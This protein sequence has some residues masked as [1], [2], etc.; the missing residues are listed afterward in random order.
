MHERY[1][2]RLRDLSQERQR[3]VNAD[4]EASEL[5]YSVP[6]SERKDY[7]YRYDGIQSLLILIHSQ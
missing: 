3:Q 1:E 5:D 7:Q 6:F 4:N 2:D